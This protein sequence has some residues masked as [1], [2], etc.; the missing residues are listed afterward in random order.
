M[1]NCFFY[2]GD[3]EYPLPAKNFLIPPPPNIYSL[4]TKS[5][6]SLPVPPLNK[7]YNPIKTSFLA[8][9]TP[10]TI[11]VLISYFFDTQVMVISILIEV[12]Y[13]QVQIIKITPQVLT[14]G[15][16]I[17]PAVFTT[18]LLFKFHMTKNSDFI[19]KPW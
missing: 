6:S 14:T 18:S 12:Q 17:P 5:Q 15:K 4:P 3:G 13:S 9:V 7:I 2:W 1:Y 16:K 8:V 10:C 19:L 11:F